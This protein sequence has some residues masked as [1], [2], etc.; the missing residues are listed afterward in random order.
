MNS[1]KFHYLHF[2]TI[3]VLLIVNRFVISFLS[4]TNCFTPSSFFFFID[5]FSVALLLQTFC[6]SYLAPKQKKTGFWVTLDIAFISILLLAMLVITLFSSKTYHQPLTGLLNAVAFIFRSIFLISLVSSA[7]SRLSEKSINGFIAIILMSV[8]IPITS[9][10]IIN[11]PLQGDEPFYLL[12]TYS[13]IYDHDINLE[14]NYLN[15]DSLLFSSTRL[16]P[17][18]FDNFKGDKLVSRH[19]PFF[20]F[21]LIPA[22]LV[23]RASGVLFFM[24][25][26]S[27]ALA[28]GLKRLMAQF[29]IPVRLRVWVSCLIVLS[30]PVVLYTQAIFI[31]L[32]A[33]ALGAIILSLCI[34]PAKI[35][36]KILLLI[37]VL[38][39]AGALLK[40]RL[41]FFYLPPVVISLLIHWKLKKSTWIWIGGLLTVLA[42][43]GFSNLFLFGSILGRYSLQDLTRLSIIRAFRGTV[44]LFWDQQYGLLPINLSYILAVPGIYY[45][46]KNHNKLQFLIWISAITPYFLLVALY[47]ELS[48]GHCPKGRFLIA[49]IPLLALPISA[50]LNAMQRRNALAVLTILLSFSM[51]ITTLLLAFPDWQTVNPGGTDHLL[52][53]FNQTFQT[54]ILNI[55]PS[56]DRIEEGFV[57]STFLLCMCTLAFSFFII[58][59]NRWNC[60]FLSRKPIVSGLSL[61]L[62]VLIAGFG[63]LQKFP[64]PWMHVE[65]PTFEHIGNSEYFWEEPFYWDQI[66]PPPA[67]PYISGIRLFPGGSIIRKLSLRKPLSSPEMSIML[68][69]VARANYPNQTIPTLEVQI[70]RNFYTRIPVRSTDFQSYFVPWIF[71]LQSSTPQMQLQFSEDNQAETF[72]DIDKIQLLA[73]DRPWPVIYPDEQCLYPVYFR[74]LTLN[75]IQLPEKPIYQGQSFEIH[76]D[77]SLDGFSDDLDIELLFLAETRA[78]TLAIDFSDILE[79]RVIETAIPAETGSGVFNVL[80]SVSKKNEPDAY[81]FPEGK[82]VFHLGNRAWVGCIE[83]L[84][85]PI[86]TGEKWNKLALETDS[87]TLTSVTFLPKV[88]HLSRYSQVELVLEEPAL[89][90]ELILISHLS[91]VFEQIPWET[92]IGNIVINSSET[93]KV[94]PIIIGRHT[95][96]AMYEFGGKAVRL[97]HRQAPIA[98]RLSET[99]HWPRE[100]KG[101]VYD[102]VYYKYKFALDTPINTNSLTISTNDIPGV[103]NIFSIGLI[104]EP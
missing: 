5:A 101:I 12:V 72:I 53:V 41:L 10:R 23:A 15:G 89:V 84:T 13:L 77:F 58:I 65:D 16:T 79:N 18:L 19:P 62:L 46:Y 94:L 8:I 26:F 45:L 9:W 24:M 81:F 32:P 83:I 25:L 61:C 104:R 97:P 1:K 47:A 28:Y 88:C 67:S 102:S 93:G 40:T 7:T 14:N 103:W 55:I 99:L 50:C 100:F 2:L 34:N 51:P 49:W 92:H 78:Y 29:N 76:A 71:G 57:R 22:F 74:N 36:P 38:I 98:V 90:K 82:S 48:G 96:E 85:A 87:I 75:S 20:P 63:C 86:E 37:V 80:M 35:R 60:S 64:S 42:I 66:H 31:E 91:H 17:Q 30:A 6:V 70:G 4:T 68:E 33:A 21:L 73:W 3:A 95:A 56:F 54:D 69:I 11:R 43:I 27:V 44:G 52:T 59:A 39:L